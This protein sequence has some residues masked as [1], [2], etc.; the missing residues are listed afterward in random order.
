MHEDSSITF[1]LSET[2]TLGADTDSLDCNDTVLDKKMDKKMD[3]S[4]YV[5]QW[6]VMV[7]MGYSVSLLVWYHAVRLMWQI[8][9]NL[10]KTVRAS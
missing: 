2:E 1:D 7:S 4:Q 5:T 10:L 3:V 8:I 6:L 9:R